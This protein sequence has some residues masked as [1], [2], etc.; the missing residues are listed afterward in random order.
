MRYR[1][2]H[3]VEYVGTDAAGT[4]VYFLSDEQLTPEDQDSSTDLYLWSEET[5]S[6]TLVSKANVLGGPGEAGNSDDCTGG[7]ET[8][9]ELLTTKCGVATYTQWFFCGAANEDQGGG[10]CLSDNSI[11]PDSGDI[12]FYSPEQLDGLRGVPNQQNLYVYHEGEV[13]YVTTLTGPP[14]CY[15]VSIGAFCRRMMRMQVSADGKYMAFVT[16]SP[17]TPVRQRR[18]SRDVPLRP[19]HAELVCV[20]CIPDGSNADLRRRGEPG[21]PVHVGRRPRLLHHRRRRWS[22]PTPT[23]PRTSTST[24]RAGRS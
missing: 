7:L 8:Q 20:S 24:S 13:H 4:K 12:Y 6:I 2:G 16:A 9:Q 11:A 5:D 14:D 18:A 15:E 1:D 19:G 23:A 17:V 21:R 3:Y 10:N 22:T